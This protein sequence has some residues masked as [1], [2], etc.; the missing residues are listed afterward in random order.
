MRKC[1]LCGMGMVLAVLAV[2]SCGPKAGLDV[3]KTVSDA[4]QMAS[5]GNVD[6]AVHSLESFYGSSYY[7]ESRSV[8]LK[9]L[10]EMEVKAGR[11]DAARKRYMNA[12]A[13]SPELAAMTF[14][15]IEDALLAKGRYQELTDWCG[16][17][18]SYKL[19]DS[20]FVALATRHVMAVSALGRMNEGPQVV[21][22]Y[23]PL[24]T[25]PAALSL[26]NGYFRSSMKDRQWGQAE[27]VLNV[28]DQVM[29]DSPGK[30]G[31]KVSCTVS[32][33]LERDG[34]KA[35]D[36]Y[37]RGVM[38]ATP[39]SGAALSLRLLGGAEVA[40]HELATADALY[41]FGLIDDLNFP[42]LREVAAS[43]WVNVEG[44]RGNPAELTR[45]LK[46]LQSKQIPG[47]VIIDLISQNYTCL[48]GKTP[49]ES[50]SP[51]Q[52][53]CKTLRGTGAEVV[54]LRQLDGIL[55]DISYFCED[56]EEALKIIERGLVIDDPVRKAMMMNKVNAHIA[57]KKGDY[58]VAIAF[59]RNFMVAIEKDSAYT[60]DPIEQIRISPSMILGMN[61]RRI[62]D[63]W[64][65]A[66]SPQEATE[67]YAEARKYY[68][69]AL[70]EFPDSA[71]GEHRKIIREMNEIP[72]D[73]VSGSGSRGLTDGG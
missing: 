41:E 8:F 61:A 44:K 16:S 60:L 38:R 64:G 26:V 70:K 28:M 68:E 50:F 21:G 47:D 54:Y 22:R 51:L 55:L 57:L 49:R 62:G 66:G 71:S 13:E 29:P 3:S 1:L 45:R 52:E 7:K 72:H 42:L 23:L 48:L 65:K 9:A 10:L 73:V 35:A 59:F 20:A 25:E 5:D 6:Q 30:R 40:A 2:I 34:W 19:G 39:D 36:E 53:F 33:L 67:A 58:R 24:L 46:I 32:L 43:G 18:T 14:G 15:I 31:A 37:F 4:W 12:V 63:L 17:L 56:Y 11:L 27:N 69:N